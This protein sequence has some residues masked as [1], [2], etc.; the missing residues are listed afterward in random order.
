M[1]MTSLDLLPELSALPGEPEGPGASNRARLVSLLESDLISRAA[2]CALAA[3]VGMWALYGL[4]NIDDALGESLVSAY[5]SQYPGLA[6]DHLLHEHW[7]ALMEEGPDSMAGFLSGLKG[8]MA[9]FQAADQM[10]GAGWTDVVISPNPTQ[11]VWDIQA[12]SP[13][14]GLEFWQVKNVLAEQAGSIR[15]LMVDNPDVNFAVNSEIYERIS[16]SVPALAERMMDTGPML[17]VDGI[18]DGLDTLT[19][20]L[21][22]DIPDGLGEIIPYA[23]VVAGAV[24]LIV[25]VVQTESTF[26]DADRT[27]INKIHVV[28]TLTLMSRLGIATLMAT[29]GTTAGSTLG[30]VVPGVGNLVSGFAGLAAGAGLGIYINRKLEPRLLELALDMVGLEEDGLFYFKNKSRIDGLALSFRSTALPAP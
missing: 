10:E 8:K 27:T 11:A 17:Q 21:G 15:Q 20:N 14:G 25:Q 30:T 13:E 9:E 23:A 19:E 16:Q 1:S 2:E 7:Q 29:L 5:Q 4:D 3:S 24:R 12:V 18:G 26:R 6:A 22:I 28:Q